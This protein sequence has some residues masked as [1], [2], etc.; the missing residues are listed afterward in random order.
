MVKNDDVYSFFICD[1]AGTS[2]MCTMPVAR[3]IIDEAQ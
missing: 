3:Y 2:Q 1:A